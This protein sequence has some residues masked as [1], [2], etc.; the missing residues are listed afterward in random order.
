MPLVSYDKIKAFLLIK[1]KNMLNGMELGRYC[2]RIEI[3]LIL[4]TPV[5]NSHSSCN[6][7][8]YKKKINILTA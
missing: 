6:Y 2:Y 8:L 1:K 4:S 3:Y 7:Y 5:G